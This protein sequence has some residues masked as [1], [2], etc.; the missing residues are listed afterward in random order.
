MLFKFI[1]QVI[2][3]S[4]PVLVVLAFHVWRNWEYLPEPMYTSNLSLNMKL[5]KGLEEKKELNIISVGSS[6]NLNNLSSQA[7]SEHWPQSTY[8]NFGFWGCDMESLSKLLPL[9]LNRTNASHVI[10]TSNLMDFTGTA[11]RNPIDVESIRN[12]LNEPQIW[13]R[14]LKHWNLPFYLR[15]MES[16]HIRYLDKANY[17]YLGIDENGGSKLD[18]PKERISHY[19]FN[20]EPPKSEELNEDQYVKLDSIAAFAKAHNTELTMLISPY[21]AGI[22]SD[23]E[24]ERIEEHTQRVTNILNAHGHVVVSGNDL[25]WPDADFCD[26]SH[27]NGEAAYR[28]SKHVLAKLP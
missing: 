21:R 17:E 26:S 13:K 27:L 2:L 11:E 16:N 7:V 10:L 24:R 28:F 23:T 19:R 8:F 15:N 14:Y 25:S 9:L 6:M 4:L 12:T 3:L 22:L 5:Q 1:R 18:V 20:L